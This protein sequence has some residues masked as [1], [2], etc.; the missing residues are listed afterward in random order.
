M[1]CTRKRNSSTDFHLGPTQLLVILV[2]VALLTHF[3]ETPGTPR[4]TWYLGSQ[5]PITLTV[6]SP[7]HLTRPDRVGLDSLVSEHNRV[8]VMACFT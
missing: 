4:S 2:I 6:V 5:R 1:M 8:H 3:R 7:Q